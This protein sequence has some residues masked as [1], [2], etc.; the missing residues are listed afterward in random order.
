[1]TSYSKNDCLL[2]LYAPASSS[3]ATRQGSESGKCA[4]S[5]ESS[6][7][8]TAS[9]AVPARW[10]LAKA[11]QVICSNPFMF[12]Y[13][14]AFKIYTIGVLLTWHKFIL[15]SFFSGTPLPGVS[16]FLNVLLPRIA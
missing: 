12:I 11:N 1:M 10:T 4:D 6:P 16:G 2:P 7:L 9:I 15:V 8:S 5:P 3:R 13:I 14:M